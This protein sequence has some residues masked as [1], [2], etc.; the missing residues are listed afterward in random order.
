MCINFII[1]YYQCTVVL[2]QCP[3][4][5]IYM[6]VLLEAGVAVPVCCLFE[7]FFTGSDAALLFVLLVCRRSRGL[8]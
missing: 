6:P 2:M 1:F 4:V 7:Y 8:V 5:S 3:R